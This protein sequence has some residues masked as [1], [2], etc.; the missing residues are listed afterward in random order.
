MLPTLDAP[1]IRFTAASCP[2]AFRALNTTPKPPFPTTPGG[3]PCRKVSVLTTPSPRCARTRST[4]TSSEQRVSSAGLA[5]DAAACG[6]CKETD[7]TPVQFD[8]NCT[9]FSFVGPSL[10]SPVVVT[11][12][13]AV[14]AILRTGSASEGFSVSAA[15]ACGCGAVM[16]SSA[17]FFATTGPAA[18]AATAV[19]AG[20]GGG[21]EGALCKFGFGCGVA[22][23]RC[24]GAAPPLSRGGKKNGVTSRPFAVPPTGVATAPMPASVPTPT[25]V[26]TPNAGLTGATGPTPVVV[27][28]A[29]PPAGVVPACVGVAANKP[30]RNNPGNAGGA[31]TPPPVPGKNI[32]PP[33]GSCTCQLW[34]AGEGGGCNPSPAC[35]CQT[36]A[37]AA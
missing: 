25:G 16:A 37:L 19:A 2:A 9:A 24:A 17:S 12:S 6:C 5:N 14:G 33:T 26:P 1:S 18:N 32:L 21:L 11:P 35:C 36:L 28:A 7:G 30:P 22:I 23:R 34:C 10:L 31:A 29:M 13:L 3:N 8:V 4:R 20:N 15:G 27:A